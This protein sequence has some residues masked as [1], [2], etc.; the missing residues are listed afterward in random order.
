M[1]YN[2][3]DKVFAEKLRDI[4]KTPSADM[5]NRLQERQQI[6][7]QKSLFPYTR[8]ACIAALFVI[9]I[10]AWQPIKDAEQTTDAKK[11]VLTI[12]P[13]NTPILIDQNASTSLIS[14]KVLPSH[15]IVST[16]VTKKSVRVRDEVEAKS[17]LSDATTI[18]T[19]TASSNKLRLEEATLAQ[20]IA[21]KNEGVIVVVNIAAEYSAIEEPTENYVASQSLKKKSRAGKLFQQLKKVRNGEKVNWKELGISSESVL[22]LVKNGV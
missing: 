11:Q 13:V 4:E 16:K 15:S 1:E 19:N 10:V 12:H 9:G 2:S 14:K 8:V 18:A 21:S 22:A 20:P 3:V 17:P 7:R 6:S 5:W